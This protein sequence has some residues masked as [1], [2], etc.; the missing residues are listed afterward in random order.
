MFT[1]ILLLSTSKNIRKYQKISELKGELL[2]G[3]TFELTR[4]LSIHWVTIDQ[5]N[6]I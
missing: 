3:T 6:L 2:C 1:G 4:V 5:V